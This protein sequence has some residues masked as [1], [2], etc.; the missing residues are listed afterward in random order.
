MVVHKT[1]ALTLLASEVDPY[2]DKDGP[3]TL[4]AWEASVGLDYLCQRELSIAR[5]GKV[6]I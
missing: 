6:M 3:G 5:G 2:G 1:W 4:R